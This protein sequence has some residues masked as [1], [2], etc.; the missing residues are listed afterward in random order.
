MAT[1]RRGDRRRTALR[2]SAGRPTKALSGPTAAASSSP[3][4][5]ASNCARAASLVSITLAERTPARGRHERLLR[6]QGRAC[7]CS[8]RSPRWSW[9]R[10]DPGQRRRTRP[11]RTRRSPRPP[12]VPGVV[13]DYLANTALGRAGTPEEIAAPWCSWLAEAAMA[14][15]R[16]ARPQRRAHLKRYPDVLGHVMKLAEAQ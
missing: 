16:G 14:D 11:R 9:R 7:R 4:T 1:E 5:R 13:E 6:G 2:V 3:S 8:P 10:A 12:L 15:R